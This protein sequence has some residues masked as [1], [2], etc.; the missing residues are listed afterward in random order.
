MNMKAE[1]SYISPSQFVRIEADA[2]L[3]LADRLDGGMRGPFEHAVE[4][5]RAS[6]LRQQRIT[7]T[8]IGKSGLIAHKI[9]AILRSTCSPA[10]F[11]HPA[12]ASHGEAGILAPSGVVIALGTAAPLARSFSSF[13][14]SSAST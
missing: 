3:R 9:A 6:V 1:T 5:I 8:G 4:L 2:L 13:H 11:M 12:E 10:H 7:V 14:S